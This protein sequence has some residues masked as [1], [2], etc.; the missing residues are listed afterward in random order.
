MTELDSEI[1]EITGYNPNEFELPPAK[2]IAPYSDYGLDTDADGKFNYLV[3]NVTINNTFADLY[4]VEG[5]LFDSG[6]K[7]VTTNNNLTFINEGDWQVQLYFDGMAIYRNK[8]NLNLSDDESNWMD[9]YI[10]TT[11]HYDWDQFQVPSIVFIGPHSDYGVDTDSDS[12]FNYLVVNVTVLVST[13]GTYTIDGILLDSD[14]SLIDNDSNITFLN[15]G[16]QV[17][18]LYFYGVSIHNNAQNDSYTVELDAYNETDVWLNNDTYLTNFYFYDKFQP[19]P[20]KFQDPHSDYGLDTDFDSFFNYLVLNIT[21]NVTIAGTYNIE[22]TLLEGFNLIGILNET[23][24]LDPGIQIVQFYFSGPAIFQNG[25]N[26][27]FIAFLE[28]FNDEN[29]SINQDMYPTYFYFYTQFDPTDPPQPPENLNAILS[30]GN[31]DVMIMWDAS[32]DDG[33]GEDDVLGYSVYKSSTGENGTYDFT[34]WILAT[35]SPSYSWTDFDA[36]NGDLNDYFYIVRA[37]CTINDEEQNLIKAGKFVNHLILDWN[38][39]SVPLIQ[40]DSSRDVV[41]QTL[42]NNYSAVQGYHAGKSQPWLHW[43]RD[44]PNQFNDL[45]EINH[46]IGYFIYMTDSDYHITT[47]RVP[48]DTQISLKSGWNLLA[49][50]SF[51]NNTIN[52]AFSSIDGK[53]NKVQVFNPQTD[54]WINLDPSDY[55]EPGFGYWIHTTEDCVLVI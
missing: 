47:G 23:I 5:D 18:K 36:G 17:V 21:V 8:V 38:L 31:K 30:G 19:P 34:A 55:M 14:P 51:V 39:V 3:V 45:I 10:H 16:I 35:D 24:Y 9:S 25:N 29:K 22:C 26:S 37:N 43:K 7:W 44:K 50:P 33:A 15:A 20:A 42:E 13:A 53:Y 54:K 6:S 49:Y 1:Y 40:I 46:S 52:S 28:L 48:T 32:A 12:F 11:D 4:E 2:F 41:H 27:I